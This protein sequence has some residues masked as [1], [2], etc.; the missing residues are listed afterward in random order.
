MEA[1]KNSAEFTVS[2]LNTVDETIYNKS[3]F[4]ASPFVRKRGFLEKILK[5]GYVLIFG[6]T[7]GV[8]LKKINENIIIKIGTYKDLHKECEFIKKIPQ[9]D[10]MPYLNPSEFICNEVDDEYISEIFG[11]LIA[12]DQLYESDK[13]ICITMPFLGITLMDYIGFFS[14]EHFQNPPYF[15]KDGNKQMSVSEFKKLSQSI[16]HL[17]KQLKE[18]HEHLFFHTDI[19]L[20]NIMYNPKLNKCL[21]IDFDKSI[22]LEKTDSNKKKQ[23]YSKNDE[24]NFIELV[25]LYAVYFALGNHYIFKKLFNTNIIQRLKL[26][27]SSNEPFEKLMDDYIEFVNNLNE[28]SVEQTPTEK[29]TFKTGF[30]SHE[31]L[32]A[33]EPLPFLITKSNSSKKSS[34]KSNSSKKS[35]KK[36]NSSKKS[37]KKSNSSKKSSKKSNSSKK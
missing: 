27:K 25:V 21:F 17:S 4:E 8:I 31:N 18:M 1:K 13:Y 32:I 37:S 3:V 30:Y 29:N 5:K 7:T 26:F 2:S 19:K 33:K 28:T 14:I 12:A 10:D 16:Y 35:S 9:F 15:L 22:I 36:S 23:E 20:N 24:V 11:P 6:A 34:K